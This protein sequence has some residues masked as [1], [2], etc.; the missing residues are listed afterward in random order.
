[1][2]ADEQ[3]APS[4]APDA[5]EA[6]S[7]PLGRISLS[8]LLNGDVAAADAV[9]GSMSARSFVILGNDTGD[10]A[11][12]RAEAAVLLLFERAATDHEG[13]RALL[14]AVDAAGVREL[15]FATT[16]AKLTFNYKHGP[17]FPPSLWPETKESQLRPALAGCFE[18]LERVCVA[19]LVASYTVLQHGGD[20]AA[21][22][23]FLDSHG[24]LGVLASGVSA[25]VLQ[26]FYYANSPAL[27]E[28][29]NCGEHVDQGFLSIEPATSVPGLQV[30]DF[31]AGAWLDVDVSLA[32]TDLVLFGAESLQ[33]F[34]NSEYKGTVHRVGRQGCVA[35]AAALDGLQDATQSY[36][37]AGG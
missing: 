12:A 25:S 29:P 33:R 21:C 5:G 35:P 2:A 24:A 23:A 3:P 14:Q 17:G 26:S 13:Q 8:A 15:G 27:D 9:R 6:S 16:T 37:R 28:N 19:S 11:T 22:A 32:P 10:D 36:R 20:T 18:F 30:Y 1:M 31:A 4:P 7:N 34:S